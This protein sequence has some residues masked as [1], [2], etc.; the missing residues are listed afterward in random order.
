MN[1][2]HIKKPLTPE[3]RRKRELGRIHMLKKQAE[4]RNPGW[5][6]E[7][8]RDLIYVVGKCDS[9]ADL[10]QRG[11]QKLI[12]QL[13]DLA[14]ERAAG[15]R[16]YKGRPKNMET[17]NKAAQLKKI[18]ALLTIGKLPWAY[19]NAIAKKQCG[20]DQVAWVEGQDLYKIITALRLHAQR[21]GY[22]L[23]GEIK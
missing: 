14:G 5:G 13:A 10:D 22:D 21:K 16:P 9:S 23:S 15:C 2:A 6:E 17:G 18:E 7:N 8:Y 12:D 4:E 20:V 19:A 1:K 3:K 11:R